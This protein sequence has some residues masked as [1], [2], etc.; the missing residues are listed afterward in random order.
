MSAYI[1]IALILT[2]VRI[3]NLSVLGDA[4]WAAAKSP[5]TIIINGVT[6]MTLGLRE[7]QTFGSR[8]RDDGVSIPIRLVDRTRVGMRFNISGWIDPEILPGGVKGEVHGEIDLGPDGK[9]ATLEVS[10]K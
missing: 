4:N 10:C 1:Q 5:P 3:D 7:R 9:T 8:Y 2:E 6:H